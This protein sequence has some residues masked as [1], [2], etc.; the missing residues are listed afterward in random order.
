MPTWILTRAEATFS[1][2]TLRPPMGSMLS[3]RR[4]RRL[5]SVYTLARQAFARVHTLLLGYSRYIGASYV[6]L[7]SKPARATRDSSPYASEEL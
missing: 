4:R 1:A 6:Q 2:A 7:D 5:A 3:S